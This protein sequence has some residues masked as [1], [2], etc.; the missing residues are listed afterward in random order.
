MS[1]QSMV[2]QDLIR[3][4]GGKRK[5]AGRKVAKGKKKGVSHR[6][7]DVDANAPL[8]VTLRVLPHVWSMRGEKTYKVIRR[9]MH[10]GCRKFGFRLIH[11]SVQ[12]NHIHMVC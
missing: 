12:S 10:A 3:P 2:Q 8:H 5:G 1:A 9:A 4:R 6:P 7:R 11:H